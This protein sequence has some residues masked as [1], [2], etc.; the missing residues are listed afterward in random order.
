MRLFSS[1]HGHAKWL[2]TITWLYVLWSLL[3]VLV[4]VRISL[5]SG[6]S[7]STFQSPSFRWYWGDTTSS[8]WHDDTLHTAMWNTMKLA[9]L[10]MLIATPLGVA[11]AI[12]LQ[13]WRSRLSTGANTLMLVPIVT[14]EIVFGVALFIVF[15][16]VYTGL[17]GGITTQLLGHVTF[18]LSFVVV[19]IRGRLT[20][21][22][23]QYE[24]AARDL[25]ATKFQALRLVLLPMLGPAIFASLMVVF[26]TSVDDFVISSFLST[27]ASTETVPIKIY[28]GARAGSTPALNALATV[29]LIVTLLAVALAG[30]VMRRMRAQ[31]DQ[32]ASL[33]GITV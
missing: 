15:T 19:I 32:A 29:M 2:A 12:G 1:R 27:G 23:S 30:L 13:R 4:A 18:T 7:R 25:G 16:Q 3:P 9:V 33:S 5:N 24:E 21:I 26:A 17:P 11:M 28:S 14:P 10:C 8:V 6:K 22:G 20:A 31:G